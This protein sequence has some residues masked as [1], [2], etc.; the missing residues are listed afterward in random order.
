MLAGCSYPWNEGALL[1]FVRV[2]GGSYRFR[3]DIVKK[4]WR[5][6]SFNQ[7]EDSVICSRVESSWVDDRADLCRLEMIIFN[8]E[9]RE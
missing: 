2:V 6:S 1:A 4:F 3:M 5:N 9:E 8:N 7:E